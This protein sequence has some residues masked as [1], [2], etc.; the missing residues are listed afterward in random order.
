MSDEE[1]LK[2][3]LLDMNYLLI[4]LPLICGA[5]IIDLEN[6][7]LAEKVLQSKSRFV[8]SDFSNGQPLKDA[9]A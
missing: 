3:Y 6:Y 7:K 4:L 1:S 8:Y 2:Y 9:T 5:N